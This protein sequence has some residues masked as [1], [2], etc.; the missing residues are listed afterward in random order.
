MINHLENNSGKDKY[1]DPKHNLIF[2]KTRDKKNFEAI[3]Q[4]KLGKNTFVNSENLDRFKY[5][6]CNG[7]ANKFA[8]SPR[9]ICLSCCPGKKNSDGYNDYCQKCIEHMMNDDNEGKEI[10]KS[11]DYV[12]DRDF[13]LLDGENCYMSHDHKNHIYL[14]V[15]LSSDDQEEPYWDY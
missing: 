2:F 12:Y 14:M 9:F 6:K 11:R 10:Q 15:P 5:V 8:K 7:C 4:Y 3:E 13:F 1:I